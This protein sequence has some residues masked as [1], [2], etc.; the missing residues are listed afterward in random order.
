MIDYA[1]VLTAK[2]EGAEW[3]LDG[4]DYSGLTW[5]SETDKPTKTVLDNLSKQMDVDEAAKAEAKETQRQVILNR[6]GITAEEAQ[7]LLA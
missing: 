4:T 2:Y 6:L 1:K 3:T 7:L 5:L